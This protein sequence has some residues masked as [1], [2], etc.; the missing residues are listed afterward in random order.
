MEFSIEGD[1][2]NGGK[3]GKEQNDISLEA[4]I[5][6]KHSTRNIPYD[7]NQQFGRNLIAF[8]FHVRSSEFGIS[9]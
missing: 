5:F 4:Q 1:K 6:S 7:R 9:F 3:I 2:T 8:Y